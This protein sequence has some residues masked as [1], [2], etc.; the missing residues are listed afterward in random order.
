MLTQRPR[1]RLYLELLNGVNSAAV[2]LLDDGHCCV[3]SAVLND[4]AAHVEDVI[5]ST[6]RQA[7]M[8]IVRML[9]PA[10]SR[11]RCRRGRRWTRS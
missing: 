9:R 7:T 5:G 1:S 2:V 4:G 6:T 10:P 11:W 8:T 3:S